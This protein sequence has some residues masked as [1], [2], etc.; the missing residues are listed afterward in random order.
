[1]TDFIQDI[2]VNL[3]NNNVILAT[4][5]IAILPVQVV[6]NIMLVVLRPVIMV[7]L[8]KAPVSRILLL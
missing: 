8:S 7:A 5:L 6:V 1:M 2:F 3:F 4:I